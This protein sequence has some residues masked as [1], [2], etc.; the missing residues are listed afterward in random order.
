[1]NRIGKQMPLMSEHRE[2]C[3]H[4]NNLG[5]SLHKSVIIPG[6]HFLLNNILKLHKKAEKRKS[7]LIY[8]Q[9]V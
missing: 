5:F 3:S 1:M 4:Y 9:F 2:I 7:V 6:N 8:S